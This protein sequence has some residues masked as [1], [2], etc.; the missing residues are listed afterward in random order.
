MKTSKDESDIISR[1]QYIGRKRV[2]Y[3]VTDVVL[4]DSI[5]CVVTHVIGDWCIGVC[6]VMW[7]TE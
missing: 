6:G 1:I 4:C 2:T 3:H 5:Y 7:V